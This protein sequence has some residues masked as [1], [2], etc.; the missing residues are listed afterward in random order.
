[1][2]RDFSIED[3]VTLAGEFG[4]TVADRY[5]VPIYL[6]ECAATQFERRALE[7]I[8]RGQLEGLATRMR[9]KA[10]QPDFGPSSPHPT[11][12]VSTVGARRILIAFNV[13][14]ETNNMDIANEIARTVR[15][16]DGGLPHVKAIPVKLVDQDR[17]QV[18][19]NLT[20]YTRT[21]IHAAFKVIKDEATKRGVRI[22]ES[23]LVGLVPADALIGSAVNS[24]KL[25]KFRP[26]QVLDDQIAK[27][28]ADPSYSPSE[29]R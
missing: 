17:V 24:L 4:S 1:M 13:N 16:R 7:N 9:K 14:L 12:G 23:E 21:P 28:D 5:G 18:S 29:E 27:F 20:N 19:M 8:R 25:T 3:C 6:Y 2:I 10:W 26:D 11:A 22:A 15:A